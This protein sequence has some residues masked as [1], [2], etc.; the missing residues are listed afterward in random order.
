LIQLIKREPGAASAGVYHGTKVLIAL[1]LAGFMVYG[2]GLYCFVLFV[3]RLTEEFHWNRAG[4]SGLVTAYWLS[5]PMILCGGWAIRRFGATTL[6]VAGILTEAA[7]VLALAA[8]SEYWQMLVLRAA[9]G[10]GK[11]M[12]AVTL[13]YAV[14]MWY[15]RRYSLGLGIVWSGFHFGG[16]LLAPVAG[17]IILHLGWRV[18]CVSLAGGLV[19]VALVPVW[20]TRRIRSPGAIGLA[21]DGVPLDQGRSARPAASPAHPAGSLTAVIFEPR[22]ALIALTTFFFYTAY[23]GLLSQEASVVEGASFTPW[24]ASVVLGATAGFA[25]IGGLCVGWLLDRYPLRFIGWIMNLLLLT[26]ALSLL[27]VDR[28]QSVIALCAYAA[29]FGVTIGGGDLFFVALLRERFPKISVAYTYSAWYFFE[30]LALLLAGPASGLI[31]DL[32]GSYHHTLLLL[33]ISAAIALLL[34]VSAVP[35]HTADAKQS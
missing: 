28:T 31:F 19:T 35:K 33:A 26:G 32:S 4:T 8:V 5:A 25:G 24:L 20:V 1:F 18:A 11:V 7:C 17:W 9:M 13:P 23:G 15:Q 2:G 12:F 10:F 16:M 30:I 6:L 34:S 22:F 29:C 21:A 14:S 27:L 3:P